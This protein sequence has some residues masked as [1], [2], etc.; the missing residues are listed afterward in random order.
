LSVLRRGLESARALLSVPPAAQSV[1]RNR[2]HGEL[3]IASIAPDRAAA[4]MHESVEGLRERLPMLAADR[5]LTTRQYRGLVVGLVVTLVSG[6]LWTK[7]TLQV[8]MGAATAMYTLVMV[9]RSLLFG[10]TLQDAALVQV[11][12]EEALALDES[13][14]PSYTILVPAYR[15]PEVINALLNALDDL[16]YPRH[17]LDVKLLLEEEDTDTLDAVRAATTGEHIEVVLV[18][19]GEP[20]TKPKACNFGL[21]LSTSD[22]VTIYDAEDRPEPL[23]LRRAVVAFR[24]LGPR[25]ACL[26]ARLGYFN[27]P[28]NII[29]KWFDIEYITWFRHLLPGLVKLGAPVPLGGTSNH[30]RRSALVAVGA[31]DPYNVTEDADLGIRLQRVGY[32]VAV[33]DSLTLE[34]ANSDFVNWAKQRSRWYKG[35]LQTWLVHM[36]HPRELWR[37][38]GPRGFLGF[39]V[40]VGGTPIL[41]MLNPVFWTL[42]LVYLITS[43]HAI[44]ELFP[45]VIYYPAL[46]CFF[47]GNA[48]VIF[49]GLLTLRTANR[50]ELLRAA[51]LA[52]VYWLMMSVAAIKAGI[53][54]V[55]EPFFWEKTQHGLGHGHLAEE[56]SA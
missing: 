53:Q 42:T 11:S 32:S 56:A 10:R 2:V 35:Y 16:D 45:A 34:E 39:N 38:L 9:Y 36:R 1:P 52:P 8:L 14:L 37:D 5:T 28:Q 23:Q 20:K 29:T 7:V 21:Q 41:A 13:E 6:L 25:V 55:Q 40:F 24:R 22:Y 30:V 31:W 19:D 44:V 50:P 43:A 47:V 17:L 49:T 18:P 4:M 46:A 12:D 26:Q 51:L 54:L 48:V 27:G 3:R 33:L 15:E